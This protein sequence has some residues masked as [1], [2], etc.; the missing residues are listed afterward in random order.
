MIAVLAFF[1]S[2]PSRTKGSLP[3]FLSCAACRSTCSFHWLRTRQRRPAA[4]AATMSSSSVPTRTPH[5][6]PL[7]VSGGPE[8]ASRRHSVLRRV[9]RPV[10][11]LVVLPILTLGL[12]VGTAAASGADPFTWSGP[13]AL[14]RI[15][16]SQDP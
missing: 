1:P 4:R 6:G 5:L 9:A 10:V 14:G 13:I 16:G 3:A 15:G 11:L 2:P 8:P 12:S 7:S